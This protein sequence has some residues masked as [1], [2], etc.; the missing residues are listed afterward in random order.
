LAALG[1]TDSVAL[2]DLE[3]GRELE[4]LS[5]PG[6]KTAPAFDG[7]GN[8]LTNGWNGF[9]RWPVRS[10]PTIPGRVIVGPPQRLPFYRGQYPVAASKDG[11]VIAQAMFNGY[12]MEAF[13]GGWIL[14]PDSLTP[15]QVDAGSS[16]NWTSVS[17]DGHWVAFGSNDGMVRVY[18]AATGQREWESSGVNAGFFCFSRDGRWVLTSADG[19]R[20]YEV[21]TWK[22]GPQL[23]PGMPYD[24]TAELAVL[25]QSDGIYRLVELATGRELARLEGQEQTVGRAAF[26]PDGTQ[27]VIGANNGL[28]VWDLRLIREGLVE[29]KLD[30][31]ALPY[32]KAEGAGKMPQLEVTVERG[33]IPVA[34]HLA[35]ELRQKGDL[36][37]ALAAIQKAQAFA[38]ADPWINHYLAYLLALCPDPKLRDPQRAVKLARK[39]VEAAPI[40]WQYWRALGLAHHFAGDDEAAVKALTRSL[41]LRESGEAFDYFPLAAAHQKV[42]N[43]QQARKWYEQG[44]AWM[45]AHKHFF[46]A[47]QAILRADAEALL[48]IK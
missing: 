13:A 37:G 20:I 4:N 30:W 22:R 5:L 41:E 42:G 35:E 1:R 15:H 26:S 12:G 3:T 6:G 2:F 18:N 19:G 16:M 44:V 48:G 32:P 23:G 47:E 33:D 9:F 14:H 38:P 7:A 45:D 28:R 34:E 27:L 36:A 21:G 40:P 46:A 39:A 8:L 24:T 17:P 25:V 43:K 10:D 31:A 11:L 29:M